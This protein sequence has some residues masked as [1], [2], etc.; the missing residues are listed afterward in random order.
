MLQVTPSTAYEQ[1]KTAKTAEAYLNTLD[2]AGLVSHVSYIESVSK[3]LNYH[4]AIAGDIRKSLAFQMDPSFL[5]GI[6][7]SL[8]FQMDATV[9]EGIRKSLALQMS[10]ILLDG[11]RK[12]L[13][14]QMSP[15]LLDGIRKSLAFQMDPSFLDGIRKSLAFQM[16]PILLDGIRKSLAFQMDPSFLDGIGKLNRSIVSSAVLTSVRKMGEEP[17]EPKVIEST[18]R[19]A[20]VLVRPEV[21]GAIEQMAHDNTYPFPET[22]GHSDDE[23]SYLEAAEKVDQELVD[24]LDGLGGNELT[25]D[26]RIAASVL[27][28]LVLLAAARGLQPDTAEELLGDLAV[29]TLEFVLNSIENCGVFFRTDYGVGSLAIISIIGFVVSLRTASQRR[30]EIQD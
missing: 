21:S 19:L 7:K 6:R 24:L 2:R 30:K 8:A 17:T 9:L 20:E 11:I 3:S 22:L 4:S 16:S 1:R 28:W 18:K 5:D 26:E 13:A 15:I 27:C 12:S 25:P 10:P 29:G 23:N 14:F